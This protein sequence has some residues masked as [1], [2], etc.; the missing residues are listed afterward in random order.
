MSATPQMNEL[1]VDD[2]D[3]RFANS[4]HSVTS[5]WVKNPLI[6]SKDHTNVLSSCLNIMILF[7]TATN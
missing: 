7:D 3:L 2:F 4:S 6:R 5:Q 1:N